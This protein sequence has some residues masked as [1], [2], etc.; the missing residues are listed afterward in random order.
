MTTR[1]TAPLVFVTSMLVGL[2]GCSGTTS[3][4]GPSFVSA[5]SYQQ[6]TSM[7]S[8]YA[9]G[10]AAMIQ[11]ETATLSADDVLTE[12]LSKAAWSDDFTETEYGFGIVCTDKIFGLD[13]VCGGEPDE[14]VTTA[15]QRTVESVLGRCDAW[16]A[17]ETQGS[18]ETTAALE[19]IVDAEK[20]RL[21]LADDRLIVQFAIGGTSSG[22]ET[23]SLQAQRLVSLEESHNVSVQSL[24]SDLAVVVSLDGTPWETARDLLN[25]PSVRHV[26]P[27]FRYETMAEDL[28]DSQWAV[29]EF[30]VPDT[31]DAL[32]K[33]PG[34]GIS[35]AVVD[36]GFFVEHADLANQVSENQWDF[37]NDDG[38]VTPTLEDNDGDWQHGTHVAGIVA[39]THNNSGVRGVASSSTLVVAK[40]FDDAGV[41]GDTVALTQAIQ[42]VSGEEIDP[43]EATNLPPALPEPVD[44]INLSL[45][46][47]RAQATSAPFDVALELAI[48]Q[49]WEKG[50]VTFAAAGNTNDASLAGTGVFPPANGPCSIAVGSVD[51]TN[52]RS[53][54]SRYSTQETLI[55]IMAPGGRKISDGGDTLGILSTVPK[56]NSTSSL[57]ESS[58]LAKQK[59][60][61]GNLQ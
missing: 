43:F 58:P 1:F 15:P 54:F 32:S 40:V 25:D 37:F 42:W 60:K 52:A 35:V 36:S 22:T 18:G 45:G 50:I 47:P 13:T 28:L 30:G 5:Y 61:P 59:P 39:A 20:G 44:F 9:A 23:P 10:V 16:L 56:A 2:T 55:D 6:G 46:I 34:D 4:T 33:P 51:H 41:D 38:D 12:M 57:F 48:G 53:A 14:S 29:T 26:Q 11:G 31:W 8:P 49:A 27:N 21:H 17:E 7:A 19:R 24:G 3:P